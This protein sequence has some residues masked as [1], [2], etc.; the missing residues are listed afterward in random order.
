VTARV[1]LAN[2]FGYADSLGSLT[3]QRAQCSIQFDHYD[4]AADPP[5]AMIQNSRAPPRYVLRS[6]YLA[7]R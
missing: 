7:P 4:R 3:Q 2:L 6:E 1:A 5:E